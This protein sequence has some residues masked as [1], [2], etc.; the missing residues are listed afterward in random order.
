MTLTARLGGAA[1]FA[2]AVAAAAALIHFAVVLLVPVVAAHDAYARL[3]ELGP[4]TT[5]T[6]PRRI[7]ASSRR[8]PQVS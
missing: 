7:C 3:A 1:L 8:P 4:T 6:I 2:A 5:K